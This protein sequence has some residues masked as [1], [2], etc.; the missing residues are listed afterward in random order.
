MDQYKPGDKV[1]YTEHSGRKPKTNGIVRGLPKEEG[2]Y[3]VVFH[4]NND[5]DNYREYS[6]EYTDG[7]D[8]SPGWIE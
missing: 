3:F 6:S 7:R 2:Y 8:L 1:H 5:W 4:C